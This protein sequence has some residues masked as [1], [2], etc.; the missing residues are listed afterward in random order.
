MMKKR[1]L[2]VDDSD[3]VLAMTSEA[4]EERGFEV[5]TAANGIDA[6]R[7]LFQKEKPDLIIIDVMIPLLNGNKT[8]R[9]IKENEN[10]KQIPIL[11]LSSKSEEEL[12]RL[13]VES[14]AE[15]FIQ[16]PIDVPLMVEKIE[17]T[18]R[19]KGAEA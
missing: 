5:I 2:L 13:A 11:L 8:A 1:I 10:T 18:L 9:L 4:L 3:V 6:N 16:K 15:G 19:V 12:R 7:Y 14:M 17:R